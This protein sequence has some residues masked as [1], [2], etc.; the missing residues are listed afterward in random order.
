MDCVVMPAI[1][2][3]QNDGQLR[4]RSAGG[5]VARVLLV[6]GRVGQNEF[7]LGRREIAVGDVD[8]DALLAFG[9]QAVGEQRKIDFAAADGRFQLIFVGAARVVQQP[10]DQRGLA[11]VDAAR[12]G[13]AQQV[14]GLLLPQELFDIEM[15]FDLASPSRSTLRASSVPS[16][17]RGR[18]R[19]PGS[20]ARNS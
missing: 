4:R 2:V 7:A 5:H 19:S 20:R 3:Q 18:D 13:E 8:G 17:L 16:S 6:A 12:G 11:V 9:A 14:L 1:G 15:L 10:P